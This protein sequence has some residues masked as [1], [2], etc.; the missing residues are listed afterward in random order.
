MTATLNR[1]QLAQKFMIR[2][3][4]TSPLVDGNLVN[5]RTLLLININTDG[6]LICASGSAIIRIG[7]PHTT[8]PKLPLF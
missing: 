7:K 3:R 6:T 8:T 2:A 5:T 1:D 4:N